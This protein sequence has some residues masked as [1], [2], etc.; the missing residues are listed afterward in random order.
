MIKTMIET[1]PILLGIFI[2]I[3]AFHLLMVIQMNNI[4]T[5]V[6]KKHATNKIKWPY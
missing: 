6:G 2:F 5:R 3:G 1:L 4:K